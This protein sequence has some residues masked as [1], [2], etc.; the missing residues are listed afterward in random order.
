DYDDRAILHRY[1]E[2]DE[3]R[4]LFER[5]F[6]QEH[7]DDHKLDVEG[8]LQKALSRLR[9]LYID[10]E[11][12]NQRARLLERME[13]VSRYLTNSDLPTDQLRHYYAELKEIQ[14]MLAARDAE[15]R[16]RVPANYGR[17]KRR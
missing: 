11:K 10:G 14:A 13:E 8:H 4:I 1:R 9:E 15:R 3:G 16:L 2:R 17:G 6:S 7:D 5:L 12:E